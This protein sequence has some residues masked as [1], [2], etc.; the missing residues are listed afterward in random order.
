M[1]EKNGTNKDLANINRSGQTILRSAAKLSPYPG[2]L[3]ISC[4]ALQMQRE[5]QRFKAV[6]EFVHPPVRVQKDNDGLAARELLAKEHQDLLRDAE[7]WMKDTSNSCMVVSALTATVVFAA[8]FTVPGGNVDGKGSP[9]FLTEQ[10]FTWFAVD[11]LALFS[12]ATAISMF[13]SILTAWYA[14]KDFLHALP[15]RLILGFA[16]L[17]L[18]TATLMVAYGA[19]LYMA[20]SGVNW[21]FRL[22]LT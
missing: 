18:A 8:A 4:P 10:V 12:S 17:F 3:S 21:Q 19:T 1:L 5:L 6:E 16:S 7:K 20:L 2:L 22:W 15:K 9:R 13:L 14:E 11:V